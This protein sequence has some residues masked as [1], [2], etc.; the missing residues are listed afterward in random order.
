MSTNAYPKCC[1]PALEASFC[2]ASVVHGHKCPS[3][4]YGVKLSS[5]AKKLSEKKSIPIKNVVLEGSSKC[6]KDGVFT[7][8]KDL[9]PNIRVSM[10]AGKCSLTFGDEEKN[11]KI[12]IPDSIRK[13]VNAIN[14]KHG[15]NTEAFQV[16][17]LEYIVPLKSEEML[18]VSAM[19]Q[20]DFNNYF[21]E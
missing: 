6:I 15:G 16:E 2:E 19:S 13:K 5:E 14:E 10:E 7:A 1:E 20:D 9:S 17:G 3:L 4:F 11:I 21:E 18:D 8:L 12:S